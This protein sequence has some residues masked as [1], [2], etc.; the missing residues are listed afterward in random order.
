M[1]SVDTASLADLDSGFFDF[2]IVGAGTSGL[3]VASRLTENENIRVLV[4]EAGKNRLGDP[5]IVIQGLAA[6]T[7]HDP[8]YDW[9]ITT[10]P[11]VRTVLGLGVALLLFIY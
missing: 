3:V 11:Q 2:V 4:L 5:K 8:E 1:A 7:Y 6:S 10:T 9:C